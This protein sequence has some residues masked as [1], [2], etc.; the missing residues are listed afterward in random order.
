MSKAG[1]DTFGLFFMIIK[2]L[3]SAVGN[4]IL[5]ILLYLFE[6]KSSFGK[7]SYKFRQIIYGILFG[8]MAIYASTELGG[9]DIGDGTIMNVRDAAPICAG[10][11][12]GGPAGI[13]AGLI[14]GVFRFVSVYW[15]ITGQYTQIAC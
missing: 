12:F 2:M 9:V 15:G 10:L 1:F 8:L 11:V 6:K 5:A 4:A 14:G 7:I 13:I 3:I